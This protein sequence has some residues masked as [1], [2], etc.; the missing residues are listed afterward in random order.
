MQLSFA[1]FTFFLKFPRGAFADTFPLFV[2]RSVLGK[3]LRAM[4]CIAKKSDCTGCIFRKT[5]AYSFLFETILPQ[6][7]SALPGRNRASHPYSLS[8]GEISFRKRIFS[9]EFSLNLFGKAV[10]YFT[11]VYAAIVRAG[12]DGIFRERAEFR[13]EKVCSD[14]KEVARDGGKIGADYRI[15][16][17]QS[18]NQ[19][20]AEEKD[21]SVELLSP[22]RFKAN[23]RY[24]AEFSAEDFF[25]CLYRRAKTLCSLYGSAENE[26]YSPPDAKITERNLFWRDFFHYSARQKNGMEL[27]GIS[28]SFRMHG[29]FSP[30]DISLLELNRICSAGKNTNFGLGKMDFKV[31]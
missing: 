7:N 12:E 21:V 1:T 26:N 22:L 28:G 14:G 5:C 23:G 4:S 25:K 10:E 31:E 30:Q 11:Y 19:D 17:W 27:G 2:I 3:N 9:F 15:S 24:S 8:A 18:K 6:E 16:A 29:K 13:V 20:S